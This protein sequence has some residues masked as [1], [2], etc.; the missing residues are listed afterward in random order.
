MKFNIIQFKKDGYIGISQFLPLF[1]FMQNYLL[2][3]H[4]ISV[5]LFIII[6][7]LKLIGLLA[8]VGAIN[9]FFAIRPLRV[10]EMIV[11]TTFLITGVWMLVN[12]PGALI[13]TLLI[14][15]IVLVAVIIPL[16][17]VGFRKQ[18]KAFATLS[19]VGIFMVF[20]LG[21]MN[22]KR[23]VVQKSMITSAVGG[24]ELYAAGNCG[25]CH[26]EKGNQPLASIGAIDLS[27]SKLADAELNKVLT[28]GRKT[29]PGYG[30]Q[31]SPEQIAELAEY[32][33][34]LRS[35]N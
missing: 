13:S 26:G 8:K 35:G 23:P 14:V 2:L 34:S 20:G 15:K 7:L 27:T 21:E 25:M 28:K 3:A 31:F 9:N 10:F 18:N 24:Q 22:K 30:K 5:Y 6:Y 19:V 11:S 32:V 29:M 1:A 33:K 12:L 4:K 17:V 16:A